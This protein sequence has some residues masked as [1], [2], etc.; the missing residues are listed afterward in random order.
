MRLSRALPSR[1]RVGAAVSGLVALGAL[2][3]CGGSESAEEGDSAGSGDPLVVYVGRDEELVGP[4]L[5]QFGEETGIEV[6]ARYAGTTDHLAL[7]LEEGEQTPAD[8]FLSQDAGALGALSAAGMARDLPAEIT[9]AVLPDFTST[10]GSWV[11][12]TG[13]ARVIAYNPE[14]VEEAEVPTTVAEVT[15]EQW[16]GRVGVAPTNA[17][18]QAFVT[19]FRAAEG[20]DA[21]GAWLEALAAN[22]P[23]TFEGNSDVLEALEN[24][25]VDL[26]LINH[27]YAYQLAGEVGEENVATELVFPEAGDPGALVNVTGAAVLSEHPDA[28]ELVSYLVSEEGQQY[29]VDST[30]EYPLVEGI[31]A[32][33][34]LPALTDLQGPIEDLAELA[35]LETSIALI[36][37]AGLS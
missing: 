9:D 36:D 1:P 16:R 29:F 10:D 28:E 13:R 35:D 5:E 27:Y 6:D 33:A 2:T 32:P 22:D 4:L 25:V 17:S 31:E 7:L 8:V 37:E 30:Y 18:F 14:A 3:A 21:A 12:V 20:D 15:D 26:G 19:G 34:G 23:Q 11:G 24:G